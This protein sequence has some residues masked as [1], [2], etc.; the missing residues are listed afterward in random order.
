ML[1]NE[2]MTH[3]IGVIGLFDIRT[4]GLG[5][6]ICLDSLLRQKDCVLF[7]GKVN[8]GA[9]VLHPERAT[10]GREAFDVYVHHERVVV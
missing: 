8:T 7:G 10:S 9:C 5:A 4:V 3:L 1:H 2:K 6:I